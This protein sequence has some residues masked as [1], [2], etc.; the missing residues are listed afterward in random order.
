M[1]SLLS[2]SQQDC[3]IRLNSKS[4]CINFLQLMG[5]G[6]PKRLIIASSILAILLFFYIFTL[7]SYFGITIYIFLNRVTYIN[8][9][10]DYVINKQFDYVIVS[11]LA[12]LWL[13]LCIRTK[14]I[15]LLISV[16][17]GTMIATATLIQSPLLGDVTAVLSLPMVIFFLLFY[18][19]KTIRC[20]GEQEKNIPT[21]I[22]PTAN[23][24]AVIGIIV[25]IMSIVV[26]SVRIVF[27]TSFSLYNYTYAI[28]LFFS[29]FSPILL[30]TLAFCFPVKWL[31][32]RFLTRVLNVNKKWFSQPLVSDE[33]DRIERNTRTKRTQKSTLAYL[34]LIV[35]L[36]L[37][38]SII[39]HLPSVNENNGLIGSDSR[40]YVEWMDI[41]MKSTSA[42]DVLQN[43][44]FNLGKGD[45][46]I[47]TLIL[48]VFT[49][50]LNVAPILVVEYVPL[51][52]G[53]LLVLVIYLLAREMTLNETTA[54][55]AA[56]LT[57][58]SFHLLI[59]IYAGFYANWFAL[60]FGYLSVAFLFRALMRPFRKRDLLIFFALIILTMYSHAYTWT[61]L[62]LAI[63]IF[64]GVSFI[65]KYYPRKVVLLFLLVV[66]SSVLIDGVKTSVTGTRGGIE[67]G[68]R[69]AT[70]TLGLERLM[71]SWSNMID[72]TQYK[73]GSILSNFII[74]S[75]VLY[76]LLRANLHVNYN[77]FI[78]ISLSIGVLP[79]LFGD[80][81][82]Q[83]RV[84]NNIPFQI[85]AAIALTYILKEK[86]GIIVSLPIGIWL[87]SISI[88]TLFNLPR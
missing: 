27:A 37:G 78:A 10:D 58:V 20:A 87:V 86:N 16:T 59:G 19:I 42:S 61:I 83:S 30:L 56:F 80:W 41:L 70:E 1:D 25:G 39:P 18:K 62:V 7:A 11:C 77:M 33:E 12:L 38:L 66:L 74:L 54:L 57:T 45:R 46:P 24:I 50:I 51:V 14:R 67:G 81:V 79:L 76:W 85:P 9:F 32:E 22:D 64:L 31:T 48:F 34:S 43:V 63:G 55:I 75:L 17:Y 4:L 84:L 47:P 5:R 15:R 8:P 6:A 3:A 68:T 60:I 29:S 52:L 65:Y 69:I 23:Y 35:L 88:R 53:P 36:S 44:F 21:P 13:I 82:I 40:F 49:R 2:L 73:L 28:F 72:A 71:K 26:Y